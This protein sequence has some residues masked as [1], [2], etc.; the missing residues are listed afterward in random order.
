M[1]L[2]QE[3]I[4]GRVT[5]WPGTVAGWVALIAG[6]MS[7]VGLIVGGV[8]KVG[9]VFRKKLEETW[10]KYKGEL[11]AAKNIENERLQSSIKD[12]GKRIGENEKSVASIRATVQQVEYRMQGQEFKL[13]QTLKEIT[14]LE[15]VVTNLAE[16]SAA[17]QAH[18]EKDIAQMS[19]AA[20]RMAATVEL[21]KETWKGGRS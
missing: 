6:V 13:E 4:T 2:L 15:T 3:I 17:N 20:E 7:S 19:R 21:I 14:R 5:I 1:S 18:I 8:W 12:M 9:E 10:S 11:L 16:T